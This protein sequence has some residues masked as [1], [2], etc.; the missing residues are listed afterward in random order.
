LYGC[1]Q[2][3]ESAFGGLTKEGLGALP[4]W[5]RRPRRTAL[6][7]AGKILLFLVGLAPKQGLMT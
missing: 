6:W 7:T 1:R 3:I 4:S 2:Q 5:V